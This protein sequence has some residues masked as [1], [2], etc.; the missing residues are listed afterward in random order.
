MKR[1]AEVVLPV[2]TGEPVMNSVYKSVKKHK[3]NQVI[4][5]KNE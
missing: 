2:E 3:E 4:R 1:A 5:K